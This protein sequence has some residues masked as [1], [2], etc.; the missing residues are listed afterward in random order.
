MAGSA[1]GAEH[2]ADWGAESVVIGLQCLMTDD[3]FPQLGTVACAVQQM[4]LK[5]AQNEIFVIGLAEPFH[6]VPQ[7]AEK[8]FVFLVVCRE[9]IDQLGNVQGARGQPAAISQG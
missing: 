2:A 6:R 1:F 3:A 7:Q 8:P 9:L 4:K 5:K